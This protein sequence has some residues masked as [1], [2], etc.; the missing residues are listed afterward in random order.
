MPRRR[1]L[2]YQFYGSSANRQPGE[3]S[4]PPKKSFKKKS[5]LPAT[6]TSSP[7]RVMT[8]CAGFRSVDE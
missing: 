6:S 1:Q 3:P 8:C 4:A 2:G 7:I 5:K